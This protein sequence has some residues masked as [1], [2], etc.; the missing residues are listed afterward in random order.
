MKSL[1]QNLIF[2]PVLALPH[3]EE[4]MTLDM[5]AF[6]VQG[7]CV[8]LQD[9][10]DKTTK[11]TELWF[12]SLTSAGDV[13]NTTLPESLAIVWAEVHLRPNPKGIQ[14][15]IRTDQEQLK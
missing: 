15:T 14:L 11:P 6:D 1:Y 10:P 4:Q 13:Y 12:R 5:D 9:Q 7:G 3:V 8:L 2:P